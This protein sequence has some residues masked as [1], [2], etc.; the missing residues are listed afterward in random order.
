MV[1]IFAAVIAQVISLSILVAFVVLEEDV[2]PRKWA[3]YLPPV[4][5]ALHPDELIWGGR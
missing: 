2:L 3:Q 1:L 5:P 4:Q